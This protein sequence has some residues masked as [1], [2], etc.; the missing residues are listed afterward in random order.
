ME[1]SKSSAM[2]PCWVAI[3]AEW[4]GS[5]ERTVGFWI[6]GEMCFCPLLNVGVSDDF[7]G[8]ASSLLMGV[9][10]FSCLVNL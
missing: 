9:E 10:G 7:R 4:Y 2:L 1:K 6:I 5:L 3:L 8:S